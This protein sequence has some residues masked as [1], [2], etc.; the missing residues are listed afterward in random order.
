MKFGQVQWD[1]SIWIVCI[2]QVPI[3]NLQGLILFLF[4]TSR[5][6]KKESKTVEPSSKR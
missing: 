6:L 1:G 4:K 2:N 5:N 3:N